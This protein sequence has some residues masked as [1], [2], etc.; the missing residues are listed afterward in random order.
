MNTTPTVVIE[1]ATPVSRGFL[2]ITKYAIRHS[3]PDGGM[4]GTIVREVMERGNAAAVLIYDPARDEVLLS[5]EF[6]IGNAVN[7]LL[8]A[9]SWSI[10]PVAG[11]I[12]NGESGLDCVIREAREE[13]GIDIL[14]EN[15]IGP[16][17][18]F[19]SP[20][21]TSERLDVFVAIADVTTADPA[22]M[23][24]DE[25]EHISP[26]VMSRRAAEDIAMSSGRAPASLI[27]CLH[28]L[29]RHFPRQ[30]F[31]LI[32]SS[33]G[34]L[35]VSRGHKTRDEAV[36]ALRGVVRDVAKRMQ[37]TG[38]GELVKDDADEDDLRELVDDLDL[39]GVTWV[40]EQTAG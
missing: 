7:A 16:L 21:G 38:S 15:V 8:P 32:I 28:L 10:G 1:S 3:T 27:A 9:D 14:A 26:V 31:A 6:R 23:S 35:E 20:G 18:Y 37:G 40:I 24:N 4:S 25:G 39:G 30:E 19:S 12:E 13:V 29:S 22:R 34:Q 36:E 11:M 5:E 17:S 33:D 2:N